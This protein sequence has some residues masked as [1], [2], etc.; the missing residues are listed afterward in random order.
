[1]NRLV[2]LTCKFPVSRVSFFVS[3]CCPLLYVSLSRTSQARLELEIRV[4]RESF[5]YDMQYLLIPC[6]DGRG[7]T[8]LSR[9]KGERTKEIR[10]IE[11]YYDVRDPMPAYS[12]AV[13]QSL[14][15]RSGAFLCRVCAARKPRPAATFKCRNKNQVGRI[16]DHV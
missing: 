7:L 3:A 14:P 1:M 8:R 2:S 9:Q 6:S 16:D 11:R 5:M 4:T 12:Y 15:Q 10:P 13:P